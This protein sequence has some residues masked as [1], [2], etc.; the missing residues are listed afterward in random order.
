M[1]AYFKA[2]IFNNSNRVVA[3]LI[4]TAIV[5][6]MYKLFFEISLFTNQFGYKNMHTCFY[7]HFALQ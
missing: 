1:K 6:G 2:R 3:T 7:V 4:G 5:I